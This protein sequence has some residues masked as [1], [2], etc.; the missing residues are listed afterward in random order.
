[1]CIFTTYSHAPVKRSTKYLFPKQR[2]SKVCACAGPPLLVSL[3]L[4]C[5]L[6]NSKVTNVMQTQ[7]KGE[8]NSIPDRKYDHS[9]N[10]F[11]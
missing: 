11:H 9:G 1:M 7:Q 6:E 4:F 10:N 8:M 5:P 2:N 3:N